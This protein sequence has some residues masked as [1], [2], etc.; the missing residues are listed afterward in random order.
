MKL[1]GGGAFGEVYLAMSNT[2]LE[3]VAIKKIGKSEN[4]ST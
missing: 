3:I 2:T 1:I 4:Y